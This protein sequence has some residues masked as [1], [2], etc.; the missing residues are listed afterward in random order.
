MSTEGFRR[1][2]WVVLDG[3]GFEHARRALETGKC[4]ALTTIAREGYLGPAM[5][6]QPVCQTPPALLA[7]FTGTQPA[8]NG[9]WGYYMP[10]PSRLERSISGFHGDLTGTR[11]IWQELEDRGL[12]YSLMNVAFRNDPLWR[13]PGEH[14]VFGFDGYRLW[15]RPSLHRLAK[16]PQR[17]VHRG[18]RLRAVSSGGSL[19]VRKGSA[20]SFR[21]QPGEG[22]VVDLTPGT[23]SF[24]HLIEPGLLL[25]NP[26]N[27]VVSRGTTMVQPP[28][29]GFLEM[30]AFHLAR[31]ANAA[32]PAEAR[33][34]ISSE[35]L[36]AEVSF[37]RKARL[38]LAEAGNQ[39]AR[40]VVG[41]FPVIDDFNHAYFD[42]FESE[43]PEG[44]SSGLFSACA[45][46]VDDLLG[47]LM[48]GMND[49]TLLVVSSDHG[50]MAQRS[51]IHLNELFAEAGL[52]RKGPHGY[53]FRTSTLWYHPSDCGQVV[54]TA[55]RRG[56]G[57]L[58]ALKRVIDRANSGLGAGIGILEGTADT[59]Y[60]A[61]LYPQ[62]DTY[63]TGR[64]PRRGGPVLSRTR[65]GGHHLSP[66]SPTPWIQ[67]VLG[68]WSRRGGDARGQRRAPPMDNTAMKGFIMETLGLS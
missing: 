49:E 57:L 50:A 18:I 60:V 13:G 65:S 55:P 26:L 58:P 6:A 42:L 40:L 62:G 45:R 68:L 61:F 44:R 33:I 46:M 59:P 64:A 1:V 54:T 4:P 5:P 48:S 14:L 43:W 37:T 28:I 29:D 16:G 63:F 19:A 36:P 39:A 3:L 7:L 23:R 17:F 12:G 53:D 32:R 22:R 27:P 66:L 51:I 11:T 2:L 8:R 35:I 41:Y 47:G 38:M 56:A 34:P 67:A 30:S 10:D 15:M 25:L 20:L 31:R 24:A 52:V 21:L 9:V